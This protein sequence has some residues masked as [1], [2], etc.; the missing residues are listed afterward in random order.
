MKRSLNLKAG[1]LSLLLLLVFL[2]AWQ[3]A[4]RS[5]G[6]AAASQAG[7]SAE[8]IEYQK[9][10]GKDPGQVKSAGFP[11]PGDLGAT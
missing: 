11:T 8:Q 10:L 3:L 7:L 4:T 9:M 6:G 2:G 1:L 5:A